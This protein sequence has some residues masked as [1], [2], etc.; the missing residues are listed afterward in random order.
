VRAGDAAARERLFAR[1]LPALRH[2]AHRRLPI[3]A[4]DIHDT[5]DLVQVAA[6][7]AFNNLEGFESRGQGAFLA[8][9]RQILMNAI[10]DE[11][12][13]ATRRPVRDEA[14]SELPDPRPSLLEATVGR[15][16]LAR[17]ER[18]LA[19]LSASQQEAV[20]MRIELD[21]SYQEIATALGM[22]SAEAA[23][24]VVGRA[25]VSIAENTRERA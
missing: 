22:V 8:Y 23:R 5:E 15:E 18:G 2:W 21:C 12:R 7:R 3:E 1:V 20:I 19:S 13:R 25:L 11:I 16:T 6:L 17:Y 24:K 4:R 9:L 10:R 14:D